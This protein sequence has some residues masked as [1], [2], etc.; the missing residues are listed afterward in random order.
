TLGMEGR[1]GAFYDHAGA[2]RDVVQNHMLQLLALVAM[3]PPATLKAR[4]V[5]DGKAVRGYRE[6][7]AVPRDSN[8]ETY[9]ALRTEVENWR[10]SGVPFLLRTGKRLPHRLTEVAIQF[11]LPP[12]RLFRT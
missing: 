3:D 4:D 12:L 8:T 10:W 5:G 2:M 1:R 7:E 6:E 9:V 11:K